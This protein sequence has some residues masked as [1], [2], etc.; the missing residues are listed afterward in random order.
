[1]IKTATTK[2]TFR[3]NENFLFLWPVLIVKAVTWSATVFSTFDYTGWSDMV[4]ARSF[5]LVEAVVVVLVVGLEIRRRLVSAMRRTSAGVATR[6]RVVMVIAVKRD[7][8]AVWQI[9]R[10]I[11]KWK[12]AINWTLVQVKFNRI[13]YFYKNIE[14]RPAFGIL[15]KTWAAALWRGPVPTLTRST[16]KN[17]Y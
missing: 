10:R 12:K 14:N 17:F 2:S 13:F 1:M 3:C 5:R 4:G 16:N 6:R 8:T 15:P 9:A 11:L 7:A